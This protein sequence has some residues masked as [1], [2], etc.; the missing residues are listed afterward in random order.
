[1]LCCALIRVCTVATI[2]G[3]FASS[4]AIIVISNMPGNDGTQSAQLNDL[5][6]KGMSFTTDSNDWFLDSATLRLNANPSSNPLLRLH[7]DA[8]GLPGAILDTFVNPP[9][10]GS[11]FQSYTFTSGY[12]VQANTKYWLVLYDPTGATPFDWKAS[13]PAQTPSGLWTHSGSLFTTNGG[14]TWTNST[15]LNSYEIDATIVPEPGTVAL[16][17]FGLLALAVRR[18]KP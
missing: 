6:R 8:A 2:A 11:G 18:R 13:S 9:S 4:P 12:Q 14:G 1:M 17:S 5:R 3:V 16:I 7:E 15:I 10:F